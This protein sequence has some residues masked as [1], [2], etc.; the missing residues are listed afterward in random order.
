[1]FPNIICLRSNN[2]TAERRK[3]MKKQILAIVLVTGLTAT[4][5]A[6]ANW[7]HGGNGIGY[8]SPNGQIVHQMNCQQP[9]TP[10]GP[11]P[12]DPA[13]QEKVDQFF[14][15]TRDIRKQIVMKRAEEKALMR[16]QTPDAAAVAKVAGELFDL[17]ATMH[18]KGVEAGI[19]R[20]LNPHM[21]HKLFSGPMGMGSDPKKGKERRDRF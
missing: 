20:Y 2:E 14:T 5:V 6:S 13:I 3:K 17:H 9:M 8:N 1:M 4:S 10:P 12:L 19:R 7:E 18:E 15:V 16:C 21:M 11:P